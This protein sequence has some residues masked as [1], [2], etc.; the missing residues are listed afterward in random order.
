MRGYMYKISTK[1][2]IFLALLA[3]TFNA[4]TML[5]IE[6]VIKEETDSYIEYR[7][8]SIFENSDSMTVC[9][10]DKV[11][12]FAEKIFCFKIGKGIEGRPLS[13]R[14]FGILESRYNAQQSQKIREQ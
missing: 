12:K 7:E 9:R 1:V 6:P 8:L 4:F 11:G 5:E 2:Y 3:P 14:E 13:S 10:K